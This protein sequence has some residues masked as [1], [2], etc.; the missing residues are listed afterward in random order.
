M[1]KAIIYCRYSPQRGAD[2]CHS[3]ETQ[4][5]LCRNYCEARGYQVVGDPFADSAIS[6]SDEDRPGLWGAIDALKKGYVLVSYR[7]D[8]IAR[9]VYL[10]EYIYREVKKKQ[11]TIEVVDGSR[12]GETPEDVLVRQILCAV[13]EHEKKIISARTKAAMLRHQENG[14]AMSSVPPY[15]KQPGPDRE[16]IGKDG[17][18][19]RQRTWIDNDAELAVIDRIR[20]LRFERGMAYREI[21]RR[22]T[23]E[24]IPP[25]GRAWHHRLIAE[26]C[27]RQNR[28][29]DG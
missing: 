11:A 14:V 6:G 5:E 1:T 10:H 7:G 25:R 24:G 18:P 19:K 27:F 26:I 16:V 12:N 21:A 9:N 29:Q 22:L 23:L 28:L 20:L 8:R 17:L 15:G 2:S 3:N 4:A 13:A